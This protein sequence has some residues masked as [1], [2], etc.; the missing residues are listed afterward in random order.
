ML[1][2]SDVVEARDKER[3]ACGSPTSSSGGRVQ[4][5]GGRRPEDRYQRALNQTKDSAVER[6]RKHWHTGSVSCN[7]F[8]K[9]TVNMLSPWHRPVKRVQFFGPSNTALLQ[10]HQTQ[11]L[12][13]PRPLSHIAVCLGYSH[14]ILRKLF[15]FSRVSSCLTSATCNCPSLSLRASLDSLTSLKVGTKCFSCLYP[16]N[17]A[18]CRL[19]TVTKSQYVLNEQMSEWN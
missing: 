10:A 6:D 19:L 15:P 7:H 11:A 9:H 12:W 13:R 16:W 5:W 18:Q 1:Y 3:G 2:P 17:L 4:E 8:M 14:S